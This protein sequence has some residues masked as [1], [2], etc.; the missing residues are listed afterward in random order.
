VSVAYIIRTH[1]A[2]E[3]LE[4]LVRR[5]ATPTSRFLVHVNSSTDAAVYDEMRR[6]LDDVG[7]VR[8][9]PR[10]RCYWGGWSLVEAT[11][12]AIDTAVAEGT[13][14]DHAVLLTGQDYPLRATAEIESFF[15]RHPGTSF[16]HHFPLPTTHWSYEDDGL[17]RIR[18]WHFE[19]IR[20]RTHLARIP[21]VRRPFPVGY[22]PYG[23]MALW[24]L[25]RDAVAHMH[26][27]AARDDRFL[28]FWRHTK[29]P[30]ELFFQTVLLNSDLAPTIRN[31]NL[32]YMDWSS[33]G[34]HPEILT[35]DDL[36]AMRG[37]DKLFARKFD[38]AADAA[39]LDELDREAVG[40]R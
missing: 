28:R 5:L 23:G 32:W 22:R 35:R 8:W 15:A 31:E 29:M 13:D 17:A 40:V 27:V 30:D 9:V 36:P 18:Y 14:F 24:A 4:R 10:V 39:V 12:S 25:T 38:V 37:S 3:Q 1:R 11:L 16:L 6:R 33:G 21:L 19:R 2:P 7:S 26:A 20:I 34:A